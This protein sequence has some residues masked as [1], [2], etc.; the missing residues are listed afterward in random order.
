MAGLQIVDSPF[1]SAAVQLNGEMNSG[2][3][4]ITNGLTTTD[5]GV[6]LQ[7]VD[8]VSGPLGLYGSATYL[9]TSLGLLATASAENRTNF[10]FSVSVNLGTTSPITYKITPAA[11]E[12]E[13]QPVEIELDGSIANM[14][15]GSP[16]KTSENSGLVPTYHLS[17]NSTNALDGEGTLGA[18]I[19]KSSAVIQ[20]TIGDTFQ[21]AQSLSV[22]GIM[23]AGNEG[24]PSLGLDTGVTYQLAFNLHVTTAP[25]ATTT[26]LTSSTDHSVYGDKVTFKATVNDV[27]PATAILTGFV[28]FYD[29]GTLVGIVPLDGNV[30]TFSTV[31]LTG[32][33]H[34]ITARFV[35]HGPFSTSSGTVTQ[36]VERA[37][38]AING[39]FSTFSD[40]GQ[41][42]TIQA[43]VVVSPPPTYPTGELLLFDSSPIPIETINQ[44]NGTG[45]DFSTS[46]LASG[47]HKMEV[48]YLG[49]G[50]FKP[51]E[52][53]W[54]LSV[55]KAPLTVTADNLDMAHGDPVPT[56]TWS[57]T[58]FVNGDT[59]AVVGGEQPKLSTTATSSSPAGHY[60]IDIAI[61]SLAA[62]N[63]SFPAS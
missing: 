24:P 4:E 59:V 34:T 60:P 22:S 56:L 62:D 45:Y 47:L 54:D 2:T 40:Y 46:N 20:A 39:N 19:I 31:Y 63:Y 8:P 1:A 41:E 13:G 3:Q 38:T 49:D 57:I 55:A 6:G 10:G 27:P 21:V 61:G 51:C 36:S 14:V 11:N 28:N 26:T 42:V 15:S 58:G 44:F 25:I 43:I 30:A 16:V 7:Y 5:L 29:D 18:S 48:A 37:N 9:G 23:P 35:G 17:L 53:V 33:N 32:G 52:S 50:N 12:V